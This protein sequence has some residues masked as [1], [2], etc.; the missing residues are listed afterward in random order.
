[1]V[2]TTG[3]ENDPRVIGVPY[4]GFADGVFAGVKRT[5]I[6][7]DAFDQVISSTPFG[8]VS[9]HNAQ[10]KCLP[11]C[12]T[13]RPSKLLSYKEINGLGWWARQGCHD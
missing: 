7:G 4:A 10:P 9:I 8:Q 3:I 5:N 11:V 13:D 2:G 6:I 12:S 1:M